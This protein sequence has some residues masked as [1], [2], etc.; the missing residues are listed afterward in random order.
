MKQIGERIKA[1]RISKNL[2]QGQFAKLVGAK[3]GSV[4]SAW[5]MGVSK[6]DCERLSAICTVLGV[7]PD[8]LLGFE[9]DS[10]TPTEMIAVRK[11]RILDER[12]KTVVDAVLN[13]EYEIACEA[14]SKKKKRVIRI[15]YYAMP[16]SAGTGTFL[17]SEEAEDFYV[18]ECEEAEE[19]DF[20]IYVADASRELDENDEDVISMIQEKKAVVLLNKSDLLM[21]VTKEELEQRTGKQ[22]FVISAKEEMGLEAFITA[23]EAMFYQGLIDTKEEVFITNL[24]HKQAL[25]EAKES[26]CKVIESLDLD[27]PEDFYA[28]DLMNAYQMLGE[29]I[30]EAVDE[31]LIDTIFK[32]FCMG[33]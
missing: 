18:P 31:D 13:T 3:T 15:D 26:L 12:G 4:V 17:D 16:V 30:G 8:M 14:Q 23:V 20:V 25:L 11:Y 32:E 6:P 1:A 22:V 24:R 19:A 2:T 10:A 21:K 5:E 29:I 33:K 28:I 27:M 7:T 9:S